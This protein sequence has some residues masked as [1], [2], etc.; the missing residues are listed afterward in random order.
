MIEREKN[1]DGSIKRVERPCIVNGSLHVPLGWPVANLYWLAVH[2]GMDPEV[3]A[4][5]YHKRKEEPG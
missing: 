5:R 1:P 2:L 4:K 3:A